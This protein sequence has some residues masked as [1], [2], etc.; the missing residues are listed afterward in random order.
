[1]KVADEEEGDRAGGVE[2]Q[3]ITSREV[4]DETSTMDHHQTHRLHRQDQSNKMTRDSHF[5]AVM[6]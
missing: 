4:Q 6:D 1:M 2:K 3:Q 5:N